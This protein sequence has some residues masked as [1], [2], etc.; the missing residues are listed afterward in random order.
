ME[1]IPAWTVHI[2]LSQK[3][4]L[5]DGLCGLLKLCF[6]AVLT[7]PLETG[8]AAMLG[9]VWEGSTPGVGNV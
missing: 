1:G 2:S 5:R 4:V 6:L 9:L 3:P 7:R 8:E